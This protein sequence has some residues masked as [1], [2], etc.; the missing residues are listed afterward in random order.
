MFGTLL[1]AATALTSV[2]SLAL[3]QGEVVQRSAWDGVMRVTS[4]TAECGGAFA[5]ERN[6][7]AR[8]HP[9]LGEGEPPSS[10]TRFLP[11]GT[12]LVWVYNGDNDQLNGVGEYVSFMIA[13]GRSEEGEDAEASN[14]T[15]NPPL[16]TADTPL[17]TLAG[18]LDNYRGIEGCTI[19]LQ[20]HFTRV[21]DETVVLPPPYDQT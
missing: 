10:F 16:V 13:G 5:S 12:E 19:T 17:V 4:E 7:H 11:T 6:D 2:S 14:F 20:G 1:L 21:G 9:R 8:F 3:A 15:Q 18:T